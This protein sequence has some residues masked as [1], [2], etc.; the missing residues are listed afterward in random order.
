MKI[1]INAHNIVALQAAIDKANGNATAH[2]FRYA[3]EILEVAVS[4]ETQ[5]AALQINKPERAGAVACARSGER[6]LAAYKYSRMITFVTLVRGSS[7]WFLTDIKAESTFIRLRGETRVT[8]TAE[9][10]A[11]AIAKFSAQF[12]V[13]SA[14]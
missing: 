4:A 5:L 9:Q 11:K 2:T 1:K 3:S 6:L 8:L 13:N 14:E 12:S 7:D 10:G